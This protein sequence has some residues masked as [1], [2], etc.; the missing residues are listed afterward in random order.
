[1]CR[2]GR[3]TER[4]IKGRHGYG[5]ER[6]RVQSEFC[7]K[8]DPALDRVG[9]LLEPATILAKAWANIE[10]IAQRACFG[11][12]RVLVT[13]AGPVGMMAALMAVQRGLETHVV[14]LAETGPKPALVRALGA[15]YHAG[16]EPGDVPRPDIVIECTGVPQVVL[17]A[18][19]ASGP[20]GITCL[21]GLSSPGQ[22]MTLD[23]AQINMELVLENDVV[24][25]SVN[26][27]RRHYELAADA[28]A[29]ADRRW[30][31]RVI[32]RRVPLETW[33]DALGHR[34]D[35][36]KVVIDFRP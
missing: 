6:W 20:N 9:V 14:D 31:E 24:F 21:T 4:G 15:R 12:E 22:G 26:A 36:V 8:L 5:A 23:F 27:N 3:Y 10:H 30:L 29:K 13:G 11:G 16:A 28:L 35:D 25:G 17:G 33:R 1:M 19:R 18:I 7:I 2:N 32:T 34:D